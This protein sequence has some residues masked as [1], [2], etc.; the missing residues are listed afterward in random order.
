MCPF[1]HLTSVLHVYLIFAVVYFFGFQVATHAL[2]PAFECI[3]F[4]PDGRTV[5]LGN[6]ITHLATL[7]LHFQAMFFDAALHGG[8][9]VGQA[10]T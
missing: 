4:I 3:A 10:T 1:S 9:R 5:Q 6:Q 7:A 8:V 2:Q